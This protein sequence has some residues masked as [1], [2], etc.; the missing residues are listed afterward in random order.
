[1]AQDHFYTVICQCHGVTCGSYIQAYTHLFIVFQIGSVP[2][3]YHTISIVPLTAHLSHKFSRKASAK[4][5]KEFEASLHGSQK[6]DINT[7][8]S[9]IVSES[10]HF[11]KVCKWHPLLWYIID[12]EAPA[13]W[14][15][16]CWNPPTTLVVSYSPVYMD[17][18]WCHVKMC[19]MFLPFRL[20]QCTNPACLLKAVFF[21]S[22]RTFTRRLREKKCTSGKNLYKEIERGV[23]RVRTFTKRLREER[24]SWGKKLLFPHPSHIPAI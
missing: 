17:T 21:S 3:C 24:C 8:A 12:L 9:L 10:L 4:L 13:N 16:C 22:C 23:Y 11:Q 18:I 1:M 15:Y 19:I 7:I 2:V 20:S 5:H 6:W 14:E